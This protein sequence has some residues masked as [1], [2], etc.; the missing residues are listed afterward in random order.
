VPDL[1]EGAAHVV[2]LNQDDVAI[3]LPVTGFTGICVPGDEP[4]DGFCD[5]GVGGVEWWDSG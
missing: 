1:V 4:V 2:F 5:G 3:V